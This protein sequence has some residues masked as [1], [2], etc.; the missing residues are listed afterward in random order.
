ME[1]SYRGVNSSVQ[2]DVAVLRHEMA[3]RGW[4]QVELAKHAG[5]SQPTV[6]TALRGSPVSGRTAQ[7]IR[8]AFDRT[9]ASLTG[10]VKSA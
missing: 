1:D 3:V 4:N 10:L 5:V 7:A 9:P 6:S 2:L 8:E